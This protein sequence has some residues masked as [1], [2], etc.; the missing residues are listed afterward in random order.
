M[1]CKVL[2]AVC[3]FSFF[4]SQAEAQGRYAYLKKWEGKLP[5]FEKTVGNFFNQSEIRRPLRKLLG[6]RDFYFLTK[7]H[8]KEAPIRIIDNHLQVYVCGSHKGIGCDHNTMLVVNL[9]TG[10]IHVAFDLYSDRPRYFNTHGK[11]TDLPKQVQFP[12]AGIDSP[13]K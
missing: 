8:T 2:V 9:T 10:S 1:L 3:L 7:G 11:F 5:S 13:V 6:N 12:S 4:F